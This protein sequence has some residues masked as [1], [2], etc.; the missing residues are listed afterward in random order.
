MCGGCSCQ[1]VSEIPSSHPRIARLTIASYWQSRGWYLQN[2]FDQR[3]FEMPDHLIMGYSEGFAWGS[4][5]GLILSIIG[6]RKLPNILH[7]RLSSLLENW[8]GLLVIAILECVLWFAGG[9][10]VVA[11][12]K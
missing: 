5:G 10:L 7:L 11:W 2:R 6:W 8:A 12:M 3:I 4:F 9:I 1:I